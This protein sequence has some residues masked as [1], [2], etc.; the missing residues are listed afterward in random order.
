MYN[1][2]AMVIVA[3]APL[4]FFL[5][6]YNDLPSCQNAIHE[7]YATRLNVPGQ[8]NPELEKV[9]QIQMDLKKEFVCIPV[10]KG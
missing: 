9:I 2:L 6:N 8:R 1:L 10:K 5:G 3:Q 4:T 7:I